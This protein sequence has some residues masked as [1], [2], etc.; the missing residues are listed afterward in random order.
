MGPGTSSGESVTTREIGRRRQAAIRDA[1]RPDPAMLRIDRPDLPLEP[2][3]EDI[4]QHQRPR[5]P[6]APRPRRPRP[7][8]GAS[9]WWR[10]RIVIEPPLPLPSR[11]SSRRG[12]GF[13]HDPSRQ[14]PP[15]QV[16]ADPSPSEAA[17]G[18]PLQG[19]AAMQW[20]ARLGRL[21]RHRRLRARDLPSAPGLGRLARLARD[22]D[23]RGRRLGAGA[24]PAA[25]P[26]R[27]PPRVRPRAHG[28]ALRH[29]H[30]QHHAPADRRA[31]APERHAEGP[32]PGD[33][34]GAGRP[35][36]ERRHRRGALPR[37]PRHGPAGGAV[38]RST[39]AAGRSSPR[40]SPRT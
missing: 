14:G 10:F 22:A 32:A 24:H 7:S 2:A 18:R 34:G 21:R 1:G 6:G 26:L 27:R 11:G 3:A 8:R 17:C 25:L 20:S 40:C 13:L 39:P 36:G 35:G 5:R 31:R 19:I 9:A 12:R 33:P 16:L 37:P 30:P 29:R 38:S 4:A 28:A 23:R 15:R